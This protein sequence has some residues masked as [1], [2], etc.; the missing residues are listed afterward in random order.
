MLKLVNSD[1]EHLMSL[2]DDGTE[3]IK[4]MKLKEQMEDGKSK[5][6]EDK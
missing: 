1:G 2:H 6:D 4:D 5:I 3:D